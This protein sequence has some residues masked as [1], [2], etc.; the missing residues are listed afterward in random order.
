MAR[1]WLFIIFALAFDGVSAADD[2]DDDLSDFSNNL[3]TDIGPLI[4][5]FGEYMTRQ[6]LSE[7]TRFRDYFIFAM[8]PI[9]ILTAMVSAIRVCGHS[10]LRAFVGRGQEGDGIVEAELCTSTSRDV[11][12]LFNKGGITR[13][14]G[15]PNILELV[16]IPDPKAQDP[17]SDQ[18]S[19]GHPSSDKGSAALQIFRHYLENCEPETWDWTRKID[20]SLRSATGDDD[21]TPPFAPKPNLSLNVGI[22]TWPDWVFRVVATVGFVLQAGVLALASVGVWILHWNLSKA[23]TPASRDYAPAMFITGTVLM[24]SGMWA[25]AALIGETTRELRYERKHEPKQKTRLIWLQPGPQKIGD[26]SFDPFAYFE[27]EDDPLQRW[28]SSTKDFDER[29]EVYTFFAVS[30]VL[31]GYLMQ[32]I[33]LRGMRAWVSLAQLGITV[34]MSILRGLLRTQRLGRHDNELSKMPDLV[35]GHE[36]DWLSFKISQMEPSWHITGLHEQA[37][38]QAQTQDSGLTNTSKAELCTSTIANN[39]QFSAASPKVLDGRVDCEELLQIRLRLA[40]LTGHSN[41]EDS[42]CQKWEDEYVKVRVS[43][44]KLSAAICQASEG[45]KLPRNDTILRITATTSFELGDTVTHGITLKPPPPGSTQASWS[46]DSARLEAILGL[47]MWSLISVRHLETTEDDTGNII[48]LAEK[49]KAARIVSAGIDDKSWH[50]KTNRQGE[51][52]LWFG[53]NAVALSETT[54]TVDK[55]KKYGLVDMWEP[56][57]G[58]GIDGNDLAKEQPSDGSTSGESPK[59]RRFCPPDTEQSQSESDRSKSKSKSKSKLDRSKL[60]S[61]SKADLSPKSLQRFSGWDPVHQTLRSRAWGSPNSA[62]TTSSPLSN[63]PVELRVQCVSTNH[64]LLDTCTQDLFIALI[65]SLTNHLSIGETRVVEHEGN[66]QLDNPTVTALAK[67]FAENGLGSH[68][69]ALSCIVP[70]LG[71]QL[72]CDPEVMLQAL[73]RGAEAYRQEAEWER[74]ELLL[75]W[76][77]QHYS[78][79]HGEGE[80]SK[81]RSDSSFVAKALCAT[82]EL[83]RWSLAHRSDDERKEFGMSGI[84]W[85]DDNYRNASEHNQEIKEILERYNAVAERIDKQPASPDSRPV[86]RNQEL[87]RLDRPLANTRHDDPVHPLG[88]QPP[89]LLQLRRSLHPAIRRRI[90]PP[91]RARQRGEQAAHDGLLL[92][93]GVVDDGVRPGV[94]RVRRDGAPRTLVDHLHRADRGPGVLVQV[95]DG[96]VRVEAGGVE[97]VGLAHRHLG[98]LGKV[99]VAHGLLHGSHVAGDHGVDAV[100]EEGGGRDG[101]LHACRRGDELAASADD[102]DHG[103]HAGPVRGGGHLLRQR[104]GAVLLLALAPRDVS[105]EEAPARR[106]G[107]L[108]RDEGKLRRRVGQLVE[109]RDGADESREPGGRGREARCSR[110]VVLRDDAEGQARELGQRGVAG[111]EG[112]A[113]GAQLA[114]AGLRAGARD[115]GVLAVEGEGV[116]V[117]GGGA[118]G[119]REGAEVGLREGYGEGAVGGEVELGVPL[120]PVPRGE[121][122][123]FG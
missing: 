18:G 117:E 7:S 11:C 106:A 27:K 10:S 22:K 41:I 52:S 86:L 39:P 20:R 111:L 58:G 72:H 109:V 42:K 81:A 104:V 89:N 118:G 85:M 35:Q 68:F 112:R 32:F 31:V 78:L 84:K 30:A 9:G 5:L 25:C 95:G 74:A 76:A 12:E 73:I 119:R 107:A 96:R 93:D 6:Y 45:L 102:E 64:S 101:Q 80:V 26:Q 21:R 13:L 44:R 62:E 24:C 75:R 90:L 54:L 65:A 69:D 55:Y 38:T 17:T 19:A 113:A 77:C 29:F 1:Q 51:M 98:E 23:G 28:T 16:Y 66:I 4:V 92:L 53:P 114:E 120:A 79:P 63:Q 97:R 108:P 49:F 33:G 3:A 47:W 123:S 94:K 100:L 91:R 2:A 46:I 15:R 121:G 82:G 57:P 56:A 36:L 67:A 105:A 8:G 110:E 115:V 61:K 71:K 48:S 87:L 50:Q 60:K 83:Y 70:A 37:Q 34:A 14:L 103:A 40:H 116:A 43:A 122:V 59:L 99:A 88:K